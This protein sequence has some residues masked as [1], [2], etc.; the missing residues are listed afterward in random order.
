MK[1]LVLLFDQEVVGYG[2]KVYVFHNE[3]DAK[4]YFEDTL[5]LIEF[6]DGYFTYKDCVLN[7]YQGTSYWAEM[8]Y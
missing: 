4:K 3:L 7:T 8:P 6:H 2:T 5:E 1:K